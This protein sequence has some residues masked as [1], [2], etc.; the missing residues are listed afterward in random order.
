[1]STVKL[2]AA[3]GTNDTHA[4]MPRSW[5][6]SPQERRDLVFLHSILIDQMD[7]FLVNLNQIVS[8]SNGDVISSWLRRYV[9]DPSGEMKPLSKTLWDGCLADYRAERDQIIEQWWLENMGV[10]PC[11]DLQPVSGELFSPRGES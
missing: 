4:T 3:V 11:S 6:L 1:M 2:Q 10:Q 7:W 9:T 5:K 8:E